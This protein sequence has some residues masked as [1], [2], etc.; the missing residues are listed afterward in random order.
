[1]M[2]QTFDNQSAVEKI[3]KCAK[4]EIATSAVMQP[5]RN[6]N[7]FMGWVADPP[8]RYA[9]SYHYFFSDSYCGGTRSFRHQAIGINDSPWRKSITILNR[10]LPRRL[11]R[12]LLAMT[13]CLWGESLTHQYNMRPLVITISPILIVE[14]L[15]PSGVKQSE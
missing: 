5:P 13:I 4:P 12:S 11:L 15:V 8:T 7:L 6:D 2:M 1:M 10:R 3:H 14:A 9:S